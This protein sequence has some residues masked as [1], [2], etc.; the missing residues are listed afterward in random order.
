MIYFDL[1]RTGKYYT[2]SVGDVELSTERFNDEAKALEW[3]RAFITS[4]SAS[5]LRINFETLPT[6]EKYYE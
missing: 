2:I 5:N 1:G 4:W 6:M 3:A